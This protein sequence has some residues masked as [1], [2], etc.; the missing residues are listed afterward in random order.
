MAT[1]TAGLDSTRMPRKSGVLV[2][3]T[4][5]L[6]TALAATWVIRYGR[7]FPYSDDWQITERLVGIRPFTI[8]WLWSPTTEVHRPLIPRL[9]IYVFARLSGGDFVLTIWLD[10]LLLSGTAAL[11]IYV[12]RCVRG[13][14]RLSDAIFPLLLL[15]LVQP[16]F[17]WGF[18]INHVAV[19]VVTVCALMVMVRFGIDVPTRWLWAAIAT[20]PVLLLV[21]APGL[22][23]LPGLWIWAVLCALRVRRAS[24]RSAALLFAA[25]AAILTV[26][27]LYFVGLPGPSSESR[28]V[29]RAPE[30][31]LKLVATLASPRA[32]SLWPLTAIV[33]VAGVV[34]TV[35]LIV[36]RYRAAAPDTPERG[37]AVALACFGISAIGVLLALGVGRSGYQWTAQ[38]AV[39]YLAL[40]IPLPCWVY[41]TWDRLDPGLARL[42]GTVLLVI[43]IGAYALSADFVPRQRADDIRAEAAFRRHYCTLSPDRLA[44]R[45]PTVMLE[46]PSK[47]E[48]AI[49]PHIIA[50]MRDRG[51]GPYECT[52]GA[53]RAPMHRPA[54]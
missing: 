40:A 13:T 21:G 20:M 10:L 8:G 2:W 27:V 12:M 35:T 23:A 7:H 5:A 17:R 22:A 19:A 33:I 53:T 51:F 28:S 32:D 3:V 18:E 44:R 48:A 6:S 39:P 54:A 50:E 46:S 1:P 31:V 15:S 29:S 37:L 14:T 36:V 43:V 30:W 24:P 45:F 34:M 11:A 49:L 9:V 16:A 25:L 38:N 4:W 47:D 26:F 41:V 52:E 42:S